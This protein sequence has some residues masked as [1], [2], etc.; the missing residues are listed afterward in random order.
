VRRAGALRLAAFGL[1]LCAL[2]GCAA[3]YDGDGEAEAAAAPAAAAAP[4]PD[5]TPVLV[6]TDLGGDDLVALS[7]LLRHPS[8]GVEAVTIAATGLVGCEAGVRVVAGLFAALREPPVP[9]ACGRPTAGPGGR[10]FPAE[11]REVAESGTGILPAAGTLVDGTADELIARR[12]RRTEGLV[13]VALGPLTNLADLAREHPADYARLAGVHAMAGSVAG[14]L[15]DGV[16]EW[17]AA[18]DP[19]SLA[20]VLTA[21]APLTLVPEDAVPDG[22]PSALEAPVVSKVRATIDYPRWWDLA[23]AAALVA[24]HAGKVEAGG[25]VLDDSEPGRLRRAADGPVR[26]YRTLDDRVLETA[27]DEAFATGTGA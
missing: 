21:P 20:V 10:V 16:A 11:W 27:Y 13:V 9:V 3:P 4:T 14:P 19:E 5:A 1:A 23:A 25:W 12:A 2:G 8:V 15:V 17:N 22:T 26:V 6:D 7:F 24:P 18:A